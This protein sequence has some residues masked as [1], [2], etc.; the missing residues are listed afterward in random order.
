MKTKLIV[1][2]ILACFFSASPA[3]AI[4]SLI[5][6]SNSN[7]V[8]YLDGNNYRHPFPTEAVYKTWY[9]DFS[10]VK[11]IS[12]ETITDYPLAGNIKARPGVALVTFETDKNIGNFFSFEKK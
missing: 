10:G 11:T 1:F 12:P 5:K 7:T 9:K 6:T 3:V 2:F 4:G 8:Y